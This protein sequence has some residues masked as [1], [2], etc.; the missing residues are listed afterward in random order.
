[1]LKE[2]NSKLQE[3]LKNG[4]REKK[5]ILEAYSEHLKEFERF[6]KNISESSKKNDGNY[7]K[8][9]NQELNNECIMKKNHMFPR[10][11]TEIIISQQALERH[12]E[13]I[14]EIKFDY[15][16]NSLDFVQK[17]KVNL[18]QLVEESMAFT[19]LYK[20]F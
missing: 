6:Y 3:Q 17:Q 11:N 18:D 1:M 15:F 2:I 5:E 19:K 14:S 12:S 20:P 7:S 4:E 9:L 8:R 16:L 10:I 13:N